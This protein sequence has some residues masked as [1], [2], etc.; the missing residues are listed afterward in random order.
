MTFFARRSA[1]VSHG[2]AA[3][4]SCILSNYC[5]LKENKRLLAVYF[6]T[7]SEVFSIKVMQFD[8]FFPAGFYPWDGVT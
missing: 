6:Q 2:S 5:G 7:Q 4:P 8:N 3:H 1:L